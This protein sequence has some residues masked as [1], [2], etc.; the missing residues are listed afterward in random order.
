[1]SLYIFTVSLAPTKPIFFTT[2]SCTRG[3]DGSSTTVSCNSA[4]ACSAR[5]L[6]A[7]QA[8]VHHEFT[9]KGTCGFSSTTSNPQS[10]GQIDNAKRFYV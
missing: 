9:G 3:A 5:Y 8:H 4:V 1:M 7:S 10:S 2:K 6:R